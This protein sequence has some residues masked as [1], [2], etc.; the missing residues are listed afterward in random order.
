M[1]GTIRLI[2]AASAFACA[3]L[4]AGCGGSEPDSYG[5]EVQDNFV[6]AC[7]DSATD[8]GST[9][10]I[11]DESEAQR[12]CGCMYDELEAHVPFDQFKQA[13][14]ALR[15]GDQLSGDV[16]TAIQNAAQTCTS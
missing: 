4:A 14:E 7:V 5:P 3:A 6:T 9:S 10:A 1:A 15:N 2:L 12:I 11:Q 8:T 13:D 16:A